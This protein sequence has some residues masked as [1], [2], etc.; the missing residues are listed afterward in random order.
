MSGGLPA[1]WV[2]VQLED[3]I[4]SLESGKR[5]RG[6]AKGIIEG[7]PSIGAEHLNDVG[8]FNFTNMRY[9][10]EQFYE[11]MLKGHIAE[12]DILIVK[13][14]ATTG[15]VSFVCCKFPFNKAVVNEHVFVVRIAPPLNRKFV[16]YFLWSNEGNRRVLENFQGSAQG[17]INR[18]FVSRTLIPV[19]PL[20]E[21]KCI[22]AKLDA[23][24]PRIDSV[25]ERLEKIPAILKR[26]RQSVLTA[27]VTGKLTEKWREEHPEVEKHSHSLIEISCLDENLPKNW[28]KIKAR[29][30][31]GHIT[32]GTTPKN[33]DFL[34]VGVPFLKV[35]NIVNDK[36][37]FE[38]KPQFVSQELHAKLLKRSIAHPGAV[39]MNI[40][41]PPLGKI[42]IIP[43]DYPEW[44]INQAIAIFK[45][46]NI[47][48]NRYLYFVL[49]EGQC[50]LEVLIDTRGVVGQ[51]NL[52]LEQC[53]NLE[54]PL[55]TLD[56]QKEIV[57]QVDKLFALADRV[58]ERYQKARA[59]AD[60]LAQSVLAKAFR[61]ELVPQDPGD[62][63]AEKL[64]Q[65]IQEEKAG[66]EAELKA[67]SKG[68][69]KARRNAAKPQKK[70]AVEP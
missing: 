50:L 35:Y 41:G 23:I 44:N 51:S 62:E 52:S 7:M 58:E 9:V 49:L 47:L 1:G 40:V 3:I 46:I 10:P 27:A 56:E 66:M 70:Q 37:H 30:C 29:H 19:A 15:K 13:D 32:K 57:R 68:A 22:V 69:R 8:G 16:F 26:F 17:G 61:G 5:P 4:K 36:I 55:P 2:E 53:R 45:P 39:V 38:Y 18:Q 67:A 28:I 21:Q 63:P 43:D 33:N 25:K 12:N 6:G 60:G 64:L 31:C 24:I 42:A 59:K 14:G 20:N 54:I 34:E 65:R 11:G 48:F